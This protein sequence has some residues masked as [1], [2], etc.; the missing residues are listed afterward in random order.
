MLSIL[1]R[2]VAS[3]GGA[4]RLPKKKTLSLEARCRAGCG[5]L[6]HPVASCGGAMRL[7][8]KKTL[9]RELRD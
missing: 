8:K 5:G 4:M 6:W 1:W 3:C 7:P 2:R 9:I